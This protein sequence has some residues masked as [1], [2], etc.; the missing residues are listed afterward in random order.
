MT[1]NKVS[2]ITKVRIRAEEEMEQPRSYPYLPEIVEL[3]KKIEEINTQEMNQEN[4][5]QEVR[6]SFRGVGRLVTEDYLFS[7]SKLG[8]EILNAIDEILE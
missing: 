5:K 6:V 8:I 4:V 7:E 1:K 2:R 3:L